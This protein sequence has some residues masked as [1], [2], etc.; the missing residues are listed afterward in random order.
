MQGTPVSTRCVYISGRILPADEAS[1]SIRDRGLLYGDGLFETIRV[2]DG[3]CIRLARHL[4]RLHRGASVL[5]FDEAISELDFGRAIGELLDANQMGEARIRLT[6][7]RGASAGAGRITAAE[8]PPT[9]II[10]CDDLPAPP[11]P[12]QAVI[13]TI[14]RDESSVLSS[15]KSLNYLPSIL[16]RMEAE[17]AGA[18]DAAL[19]N[20]RGNVS[21]GTIGNIFLVKG[22]RLITPAL[23][24]GPLPGTVRA[25]V[26]SVAPSLGLEPVEAA[27]TPRDLLEADEAFYTNAIMLV[28][29]ISGIDGRE[30]GDAGVS[31]RIHRVL[32]E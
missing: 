29:S 19:L 2:Q 20:N 13:A 27:V 17:R 6:V 14:R 11:A 30:F 24:E 26:L 8:G 5:G 12:A 23:S 10:T 9:V 25:E 15:L 7:T 16:A 1:I 31:E 3:K 28:R 21:D 32:R 18:D 22:S 4:E